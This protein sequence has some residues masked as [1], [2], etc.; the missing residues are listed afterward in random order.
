MGSCSRPV[1]HTFGCRRP[2]SQS[3]TRSASLPPAAQLAQHVMRCRCNQ[4]T[5]CSRGEVLLMSCCPQQGCA[6]RQGSLLIEKGRM[7]RGPAS[8]AVLQILAQINCACVPCG[9]LLP[10][11]LKPDQCQCVLQG[12]LP[13]GSQHNR[14]Q[15]ASA[16]RPFTWLQSVILP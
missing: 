7:K 13:Y 2:A 5:G 8:S 1:R 3:R 9:P 14:C 16:G 11:G 12:Y 6:Q 15:H 10:H 4:T